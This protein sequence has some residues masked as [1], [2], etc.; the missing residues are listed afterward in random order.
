MTR[1]LASLLAASL[2]VSTGCRKENATA[3]P[4]A[5]G[6]VEA[7][8]V[9]VASKVPGRVA[10]VRVVEGAR[11][12]AGQVVV[13]LQTTDA[14]LAMGRA[15]A[16]RDQAVAQLRLLE[17]GTRPE[18]I[19]QAEAQVAAANADRLAAA[20]ELSS[21]QEDETRFEQLL[22]QRAGSQK[23]RDDAVARRQLAEARLR[24]TDDRAR[25]ASATLAR[26]KAGARP[27][28]I[29]AAKARV[30][31]VD[32]QI[33]TIEHDRAEATITAPTEGIVSSRLVEPGELVAVGTPLVVIVDLDHA[34][35]DAYVE[36]PLVPSLRIDQPATV[37]TDAGDRLPGRITFISPQA[38]FTPRNVQTTSERAKLVYRVKVTVDNRQGV[39]KPGMPVEVELTGLGHQGGR[40]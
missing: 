1:L 10:E 31:A 7:T 29:D 30:A 8:D 14:D 4:K 35:A 12:T 21:A 39:L 23:Q 22:R 19:Q 13:T 11:V 18:D 37:I 38:E 33:A 20:A 27:E 2:L 34:W 3:P 26:L 36:E 5:S 32:A 9:K 17:A 40:P 15:H 24:A 6:Y 28:E 16:E 25:A